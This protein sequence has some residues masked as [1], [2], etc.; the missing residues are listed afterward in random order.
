[1]PFDLDRPRTISY[2]S[3]F[4]TMSFV[5]RFKNII[6]LGLQSYLWNGLT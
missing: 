6:F 3:S 4:A 5:H 2:Q 1:M